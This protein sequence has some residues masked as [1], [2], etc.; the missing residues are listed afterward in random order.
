MRAKISL[1]VC[2]VSLSANATTPLID[3]GFGTDDSGVAG[4]MVGNTAPA[5]S[6]TSGGV[7]P[8]GKVLLLGNDVMDSDHM[9]FVTRLNDDGT[10]DSAFGTNGSIN[11][12]MKWNLNANAIAADG[13][14]VFAG[15]DSSEV[16]SIVG[17]L[18]SG[19]AL[20]ESFHMSGYRELLPTAFGSIYTNSIFTG[21]FSLDGGKVLAIGF[22]VTT[23]NVTSACGMAVQFNADGSLDQSF[24]QGSGSVCVGPPYSGPPIFEV[25]SGARLSSGDIILAGGADHTGGSNLDVAMTRLLPTGD[26]DTSFGNA[27]WVTYGFDAGG[28]FED[29]ATTTMVDEQGRVLLGVIYT[30]DE[31]IQ[32]AVMRYTDDGQ[33]DDSFGTHGIVQLPTDAAQDLAPYAMWM[34]PGSNVMIASIGTNSTSMLVLNEIDS[35]GKPATNFGE[36]GTYEVPLPAGFSDTWRSI[37]AGDYIYGFGQSS[38]VGLAALRIILPIFN[39]GFE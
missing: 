33:L 24:G 21:V 19:G 22:A 17:R 12:G 39:N 36:G 29:Y 35:T 7:Q 31:G 16:N 30:T 9:A 37:P 38:T 11:L 3:L 15:D 2:F 23:V 4:V 26:I 18:T 28:E 1:L 10:A 5:N 13:S 32:Q 6:L 25:T 8:D 20:D 14:I 27:G 34:L